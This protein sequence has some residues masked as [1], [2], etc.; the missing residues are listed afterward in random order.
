MDMLEAYKAAHGDIFEISIGSGS[1]IVEL[2]HNGKAVNRHEPM[3]PLF[4]SMPMSHADGT[5]ALGYVGVKKEAS[6]NAVMPYSVY[7]DGEVIFRIPS[8]G[9]FDT[10]YNAKIFT[11]VTGH[12]AGEYIDF[13]SARGL[14]SGTGNNLFSPDITMTRAM[15]VQALANIEGIN[16]TAYT[17]ASRFN[18]VAANIWYAP[19]TG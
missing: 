17:A 1:L 14:F 12:W 10:I 13:V 4:V 2:L 3:H 11:D 15:F 7:K 6:V 19:G 16:L 8:T 9:T 5:S 18:D